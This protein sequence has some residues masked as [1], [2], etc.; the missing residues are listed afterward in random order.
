[1]SKNIAASTKN[2]PSFHACF[3]EITPGFCVISSHP[4][5]AVEIMAK[6]NAMS[7]KNLICLCQH[8]AI[9][10]TMILVSILER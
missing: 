9:L 6:T 2:I 7:A 5:M 4:P 8:I 1:M 3:L 10:P